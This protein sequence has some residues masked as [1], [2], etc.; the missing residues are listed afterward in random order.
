MPL[1][2][3]RS[4][5]SVE[6][7]EVLV[8]FQGVARSSRGV[9]FDM[10]LRRCIASV[11]PMQSSRFLP[12]SV[13]VQ[14]QPGARAIRQRGRGR[15]ARHFVAN[16]DQAGS[17]PVVRSSERPRS[18]TV[19]W[20]SRKP[21]ASVRF[22]PRARRRRCSRSEG[23]RFVCGRMR[24]RILS[25]AR[26]GS[27]QRSKTVLRSAVTREGARSSR[28]AG[29]RCGRGRLA[30]RQ[31]SKLFQASSIL[32]ARSMRARSSAVERRPDVPEIAGSIPAA[33]TT[34]CCS[35][36]PGIRALNPATRVRF[37]YTTLDDSVF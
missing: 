14:V 30:R 15:S 12:G 19:V 24:V 33:R 34:S 7:R 20:R 13:L 28:A 3:R 35:S 27:F 17:N 16:E 5:R 10:T 23:S 32:V 25:P 1:L 37:P 8:R 9:S 11:A 36:G 4:A 6:A 31:P 22:R 18:T 26:C 21:P 29:A 2:R